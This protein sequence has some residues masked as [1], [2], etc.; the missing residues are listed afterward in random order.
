MTITSAGTILKQIYKTILRSLGWSSSQHGG[1]VQCTNA[2]PMDRVM[3]LARP[4]TYGWVKPR[5]NAHGHDYISHPYTVTKDY[6]VIA[7]LRKIAIPR[8]VKHAVNAVTFCPP[9]TE[10]FLHSSPEKSCGLWRET[11]YIFPFRKS[12]PVLGVRPFGSPML[13]KSCPWSKTDLRIS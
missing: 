10:Y 7:S 9:P 8:T 12:L 11:L 3:T 4:H 13:E 6:L 2:H 5:A 1:G